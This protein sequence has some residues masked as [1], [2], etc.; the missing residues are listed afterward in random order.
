MLVFTAM[1]GWCVIEGLRACRVSRPGVLLL[2]AVLT[3]IICK[4]AFVHIFVP[5]RNGSRE[6]QVKAA[7]LARHV[8]EGKTLY[9]FRLKDEGIMFYYGRPVLRLRGWEELPDQ[10]D[11]VYCAVI[12]AERQHL[13]SR[14]DWEVVL[15]VPLVDEQGEPMILLGLRRRAPHISIAGRVPWPSACP[16]ERRTTISSP[17]RLQPRNPPRS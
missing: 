8:P 15:E 17:D 2:C 4:F 12:E 9:L 10:Q 6:P 14:S 1:A 13:Q 7:Q 3:W 5:Y 16:A 11:L